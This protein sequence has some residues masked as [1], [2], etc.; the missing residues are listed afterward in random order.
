MNTTKLT[1]NEVFRVVKSKQLKH[2]QSQM[3]TVI[4]PYFYRLLTH[5]PNELALIIYD[6]VV[7]T[8]NTVKFIKHLNS[9]KTY[10]P[11][12]QTYNLRFIRGKMYLS[13]GNDNTQPIY[14]FEKWQRV[15]IESSPHFKHLHFFDIDA[16]DNYYFRHFGGNVYVFTI[17]ASVC[18]QFENWYKI[19]R[20]TNLSILDF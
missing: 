10:T 1:H 4:C 17:D 2:T 8:Q 7:F 5:F 14:D 20:L 6:Y 3:D 12:N 11:P 16:I 15:K 13:R 18:S 9:V 19:V